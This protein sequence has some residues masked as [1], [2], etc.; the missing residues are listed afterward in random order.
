MRRSF[1]LF[2]NAL[3]EA[4]RQLSLLMDSVQIELYGTELDWHEGRPKCL[5]NIAI[6]KGVN[7][8][9]VESPMRVSYRRSLELLQEG[10][11]A[12]I[13]G[14]DDAGYMPS[15]LFTYACS[16]KP[17]LALLHKDGPAFAQFQRNPMLGHSMWFDRSG[18]MPLNAAADVLRRFL[19]ETVERKC[20]D[21]KELVAPFLAKNMALRHIALFESV[22]GC[23]LS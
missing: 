20:F 9:I 21:R 10:D 18:D 19:V 23:R 15:K 11:G 4:R 2:C 17:L 22:C 12:L 7:D 5:T 6:E 16:G 8:I 1:T 3:S 14:V 13:L